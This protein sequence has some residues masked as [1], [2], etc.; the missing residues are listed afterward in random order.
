MW[1][2]IKEFPISSGYNFNS[3]CAALR[4][5]GDYLSAGLDMVYF[6]PALARADGVPIGATQGTA[7][8]RGQTFQQW[9]RHRTPQ[10]PWRSGLDNIASHLSLVEEW[11]LREFR[12]EGG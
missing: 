11:L 3:S 4:I 2:L 5:S 10:N 9:S 1:L 12:K 7:S 6:Y 8:I